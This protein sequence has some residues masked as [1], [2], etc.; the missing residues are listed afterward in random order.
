[1]YVKW[2]IR[3]H[4]NEELANI[5]FYDAYL[6]Q[7]Y[8]NE[9]GEPRQRTLAYLGN[10]RQIDG[11]FPVIERALFYI[12]M[13]E[14]LYHNLPSGT[15]TEEE[16]GKLY[17]GLSA[18]APPPTEEEI[19][20]G[21]VWNNSWHSTY[22]KERAAKPHDISA[23]YA[24]PYNNFDLDTVNPVITETYLSSE[25]PLDRNVV[26]GSLQGNAFTR[27]TGKMRQKKGDSSPVNN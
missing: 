6:V 13:E 15:L 1:M 24:Q 16:R 11:I 4:K 20:R 10:L 27:S 14:N 18:V 25:V 5:T 26:V 7:S 17:N 8:K 9:D 12:R 21:Q 2:V 22:W 3:R 23:G 19:E